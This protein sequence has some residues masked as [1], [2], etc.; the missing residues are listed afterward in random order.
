MQGVWVLHVIYTVHVLY[1][2]SFVTLWPSLH[3]HEHEQVLVHVHVIPTLPTCMYLYMY[4]C[5][6]MYVL[7]YMYL[8]MYMYM[9]VLMYMYICA[10]VFIHVITCMWFISM[11]MCVGGESTFGKG[12]AIVSP[13]VSNVLPSVIFCGACQCGLQWSGWGL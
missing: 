3:V 6:Y 7:M 10:C 11:A 8:C 13:A 5:M 1:V 12:V 9:Y 4:M 2:P